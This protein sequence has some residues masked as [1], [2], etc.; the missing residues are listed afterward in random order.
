MM[1]TGLRRCCDRHALVLR[2]ATPGRG[3][4]VRG[5]AATGRGMHDDPRDDATGAHRSCNRG[6]VELQP[7]AGG[8]GDGEHPCWDSGDGLGRFLRRPWPTSATTATSCCD[9]WGVFLGGDGGRAHCRCCND[10]QLGGCGEPQCCKR[11]TTGGARRRCYGGDHRGAVSGGCE[12]HR[13]DMRTAAS[14]DARW[15]MGEGRDLCAA[16]GNDRCP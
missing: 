11:P 5:G 6:P 9:Q 1:R 15:E 12:V 8:A 3:N 16:E 10:D 2:T 4:G 14:G 13:G 7:W